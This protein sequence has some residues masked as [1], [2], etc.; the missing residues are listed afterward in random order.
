VELSSRASL[1][2]SLCREYV[3][4]AST[5]DIADSTLETA[6]IKTFI[7]R[8]HLPCLLH[9]C[10]DVKPGIDYEMKEE[11]THVSSDIQGH[12]G[13]DEIQSLPHAPNTSPVE[14]DTNVSDSISCDPGNTRYKC[15]VCMKLFKYK[16]DMEIHMRSHNGDTPYKCD[17]CMKSF[18]R[19]SGVVI[20]MRSHTGDKPYKC[21][22]CLKS[23]GQKCSL[24]KHMRSHTGVK[25]YKCDICFK[26]FITKSHLVLHMRSHTGVKPYKCDMCM[27]SFSQKCSLVSHMRS[28]TGDTPY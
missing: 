25:P 6:D 20:H 24:V 27:K 26:S 17:M 28:H 22:M 23:F 5:A 10:K 18:S 13:S 1:S 12:S 2:R 11:E 9:D 7:N 3:T 14:D 21:D 16:S 19:K 8:E 15:K 4:A